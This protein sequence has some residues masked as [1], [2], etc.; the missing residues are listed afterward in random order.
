MSPQQFP[1]TTDRKDGA[2]VVVIFDEDG[3]KHLEEE[4]TPLCDSARRLAYSPHP[5]YTELCD[6]H[7]S[8]PLDQWC[9]ECLSEA[10]SRVRDFIGRSPPPTVPYERMFPAE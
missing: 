2:P 8:T 6:E 7:E 9:E 10:D 4:L 1:N 5:E 3:T